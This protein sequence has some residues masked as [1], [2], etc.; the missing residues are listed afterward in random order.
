MFKLVIL[1]CCIALA[2]AKPGGVPVAFSAPVSAA[3]TAS[4]AGYTVPLVYSDYSLPSAT[5]SAHPYALPYSEYF[6][7]R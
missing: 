2:A 7:R 6:L 4:I 1:V 5:Y 3:H